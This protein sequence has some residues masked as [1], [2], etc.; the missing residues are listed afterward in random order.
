MSD[1]SHGFY[2]LGCEHVSFSNQYGYSLSVKNIGDR[3]IYVQRFQVD[4]SEDRM[5]EI[6]LVQPDGES[7]SGLF[8]LPPKENIVIKWSFDGDSK[9]YSIKLNVELP[10]EFTHQKV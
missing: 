1:F 3:A 4:L 8:V 6:G 2:F 9:I 5:A 7:G 10:E